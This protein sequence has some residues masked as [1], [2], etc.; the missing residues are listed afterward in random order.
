MERRT[1]LSAV[2][3]GSLAGGPLSR[4][5]DAQTD[6]SSAVMSGASV[7]FESA[8]IDVAGNKIFLRRYGQGP[9]ILMVHG[10]P[11][12]SLMWAIPCPKAGKGSHGDLRRPPRVRPKRDTG[13]GRRPFSLFEARHGK[14]TG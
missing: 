5:T 13:F 1:F 4:L 6:L 9:A 10:F 14:R 3:V 2:Y 8:Q 7:A 11:R 12:T